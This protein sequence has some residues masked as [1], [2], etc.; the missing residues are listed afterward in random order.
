MSSHN[1]G[2]RHSHGGSS[3]EIQ[4]GAREAAVQ[5]PGPTRLDIGCG[6]GAPAARNPE[7]PPSGSIERHR[8]DRP[9]RRRS[10]G[11][12]GAGRRPPDRDD[13]ALEAPWL[14]LRM[15]ARCLAGGGRIGVTTPNIASFRHRVELLLR[16]RLTAS[17]PDKRPA[18]DPCPAAR[19]RAPDGR[20]LRVRPRSYV[21]HD[22]VS[23]TRGRLWP[24]AL[25]VHYPW[26]T[27]VSVV[28]TAD[29]HRD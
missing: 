11:R 7:C 2:Q 21:G 27:A 4:R 25:H 18:F 22:V 6:T 29:R 16:G 28:I 26:G 15:A 24:R 17:R 3:A 19:D 20:R 5:Q 8:P 12:P 10:P 1:A 9:A 23:W 13:R 14:V